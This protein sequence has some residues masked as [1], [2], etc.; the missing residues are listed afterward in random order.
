MTNAINTTNLVGKKESVVDE[1]LLLNPN[2]TP[3]I[4]LLGFSNPV[5][6][7][8]HQWYE[9]K[10]FDTKTKVTA[11]ATA[12][13]TELTVASVEPFVIHSV[14]Q[15]DEELVLV[16]AIDVAAKKLTVER[17]YADTTA[18]AIVKDAEIEFQYDMTPEGADAPKSR[19]KARTPQNNVTQIFM[20]SVEVTG[21]AQEVEQYGVDDLYNYE[22][23]KKQLEVALQLEK[24]LINGIKLDNGMVRHMAGLRQLIKT[25]VTDAAG[26]SVTVKM[27][28]DLVQAVFEKGG[29]ASGGQY[30]FIVSTNQKRAISDLQSDKIR[31]VQAETSRGQV[32]DHIVT[33]FGQFPVIMNDNVKPTELFFIDINRTKI[34]P[35]GSRGFHHQDTA[36]TGDNRRGFIVGEYTLEFKQESAHGRIKNL[37]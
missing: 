16:T 36:I 19:Y 12:A 29:L 3:L 20:E 15:I 2:Q 8:I 6:N 26:A 18:A 10:M 28:G 30:A 13:A 17:G 7:T 37:A 5:T 4:S 9:D 27:L 33:E 14:A 11:A 32:V 35:L 22:K 34:K 25:N 1:V 21:S 24:A 23:A 31:I